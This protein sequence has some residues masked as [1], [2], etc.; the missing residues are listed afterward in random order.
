MQRRILL[1]KA[2]P[3]THISVGFILIESIS[4][5]SLD[6]SLKSRIPPSHP[7]QLIAETKKEIL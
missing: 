3:K 4:E 1:E 2:Q 6:K 7:P 5:E